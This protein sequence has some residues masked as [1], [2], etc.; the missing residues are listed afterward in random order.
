MTCFSRRY[1]SKSSCSAAVGHVGSQSLIT[2]VCLKIGCPQNHWFVISFPCQNGWY[3]VFRVFRH[4]NP[5]VR[6]RL[7]P[8]R[9]YYGLYIYLYLSIYLASYLSIYLTIYLSSYLSIYLQY[10]SICLFICVSIYYLS[11]FLFISLS[12]FM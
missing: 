6:F 10:Q 3:T 7:R 5:A 2:G 1:S 9:P 4:I 11:I 12:V 8:C